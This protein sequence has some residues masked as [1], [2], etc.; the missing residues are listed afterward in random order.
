MVELNWD[1]VEGLIPAIVQDHET[2]EI[3][4]LG[5]M[6]KEALKISQKTG[7]ATFYS[8]TKKKNLD[9]G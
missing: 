5:Y 9:Q 7:F 2:L 6:N 3:L 1:K 4:M 8:R